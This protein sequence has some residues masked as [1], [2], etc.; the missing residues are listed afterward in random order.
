MEDRTA[1]NAQGENMSD[2]S[3]AQDAWAAAIELSRAEGRLSDSQ[4]AFVRLAKPLAIVDDRFMIV[5]ATEFTRNLLN[6]SV[7]QAL[8]DKLSAIIGRKLTLD[9][10]VDSSLSEV[11]VNPPPAAKFLLLLLLPQ[12]RSR[13]FHNQHQ[14]GHFA[15]Y[16]NQ[17]TLICQH[18]LRLLRRRRNL[19]LSSLNRT[20]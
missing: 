3:F 8:T 14:C 2:G 5:V 19:P 1:F 17:K 9:I 18:F 6:T 13:Q 16:L 20:T 11:A 10:S 15:P 4:T 12:L 7:V